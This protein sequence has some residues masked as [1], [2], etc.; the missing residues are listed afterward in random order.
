MSKRAILMATTHLCGL[1]PADLAIILAADRSG[2]QF[3]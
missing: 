1:M 2:V 3:R